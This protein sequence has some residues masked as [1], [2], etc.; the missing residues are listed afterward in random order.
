MMTRSQ[1]LK[2]EIGPCHLL[3]VTILSG[4]FRI[5]QKETIHYPTVASNG[6]ALDMTKTRENGNDIRVSSL[7]IQVM[8]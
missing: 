1:L 3:G 2:R 8:E 6:M 7:V 4:P 5:P